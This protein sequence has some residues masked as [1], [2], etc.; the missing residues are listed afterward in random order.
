MNF[1]EQ[2]DR[3]RR[4]SGRLVVLMILAVLGLIAL[5]TVALLAVVH[6]FGHDLYGPYA[7]VNPWQLLATVSLAV[8]AVVL[9]G[10]LYKHLQ[11][12]R[13]GRVVAQRL[14][15]RLI[16]L[17]PQGFHERRVLN[18][19]EEMALASGTPVVAADTPGIFR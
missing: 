17:E 11:L 7:L 10:S 19:V 16:N 1:F 13:G 9:I 8:S 15:G 3:A 6:Y 12:Q 14:G 4:N 5:T 18:V 2:Q